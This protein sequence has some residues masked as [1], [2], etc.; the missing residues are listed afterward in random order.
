[1]QHFVPSTVVVNAQNT[2]HQVADKF[3]FH[4]EAVSTETTVCPHPQLP[5]LSFALGQTVAIFKGE[6]E[7][8]P[9]RLNLFSSLVSDTIDHYILNKSHAVLTETYTFPPNLGRKQLLA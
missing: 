2:P 3:K 6:M 1:M 7:N 4:F 8:L 5:I 9:G